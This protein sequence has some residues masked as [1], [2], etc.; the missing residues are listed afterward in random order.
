MKILSMLLSL[1]LP[2]S[3]QLVRAPVTPTV[4]NL[5]CGQDLQSAINS[6]SG[7]TIITVA[8]R[9]G[10][11]RCNWSGTYFLKWRADNAFVT[12]QTDGTVPASGTRTQPGDSYLALFTA[13]AVHTGYYNAFIGNDG[14]PENTSGHPIHGYRFVGLEITAP[15]DTAHGS[16]ALMGISTYNESVGGLTF[17]DFPYSIDVEHCYIHGASVDQDIV[18]GIVMNGDD[19]IVRDSQISDIHSYNDGLDGEA[20]AIWGDPDRGN[21]LIENNDLQAAADNRIFISTRQTT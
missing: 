10:G 17:A 13:S 16:Y 7:E 4:V 21:W 5:S 18:R 19:L 9:N 2:A 15:N 12:I 20:N 3:A 11:S 6:A 14:A 1:V 8:H